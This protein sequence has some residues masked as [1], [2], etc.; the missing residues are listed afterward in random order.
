MTVND[1]L[2]TAAATPAGPA[3]RH[4]EASGDALIAAARATLEA[5]GEAWTDMREQVF[6][7]V[8]DQPRP[9]SA[10]DVADQLAARRGRRVAANSIYRILD[11]FVANNLVRRIESANAFVVNR[12]PGCVHDCIFLVCDSCGLAVHIDDDHL[13]GALRRAAASSG[14]HAVRPVI[15]VRG[16]CADCR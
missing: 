12:H 2:D 9:V 11:L 6:A 3:H 1:A 16:Q 5:G 4:R 13:S 7:L 14:F 10:Y 8:A 15:E